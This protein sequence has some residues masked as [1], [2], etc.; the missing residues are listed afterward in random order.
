MQRE[1]YVEANG[2][3]IYSPRLSSLSKAIEIDPKNPSAY[4]YVLYWLLEL[5]LAFLSV[6]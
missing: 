2:Q 1:G 5:S 4:F 6:L 3:S